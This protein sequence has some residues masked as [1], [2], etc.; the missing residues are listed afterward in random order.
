LPGLLTRY[1]GTGFTLG[2]EP[3]GAS[4]VILPVRSQE[5]DESHEPKWDWRRFMSVL[6]SMGAP[7]GALVGTFA[8][9]CCAGAPGALGLLSAVGAGFLINDLILLPLLAAALGVA[10]WALARGARRRADRRP[11]GLGIAASIGM[12]AGIFAG[13]W[14][15]WSAAA[16]LVAAS[17]WN[18]FPPSPNDC[19]GGMRS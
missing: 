12:A 19:E 10:I 17:V 11:L 3:T 5:S 15:I 16:L 13:P 18:L 9:L 1:H 6:E 14:L 8:A 4:V 2:D 7:G